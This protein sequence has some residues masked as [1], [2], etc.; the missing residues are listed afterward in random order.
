MKIRSMLRSYVYFG[1]WLLNTKNIFVYEFQHKMV[2]LL[3]LNSFYGFIMRIV[4][5]ATHGS[6][7]RESLSCVNIV[8]TL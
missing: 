1:W 4:L 2:S 5:C 3:I 7:Y 6:E 8:Y